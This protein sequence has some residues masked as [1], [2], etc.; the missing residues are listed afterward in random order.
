E[1]QAARARCSLH[2]DSPSS[3][4]VGHWDRMRLE[5]V[6]SNLLSNALKFGAGHPVEVHLSGV[7]SVARIEV[8]DHGIGIDDSGLE[9][10]FERFE[11]AAPMRHYG[12]F[13][14]GLWIVRKLVDAFGGR[15]VA[16]NAAD[17]GAAFVVDLP[18]DARIALAADTPRPSHS[19]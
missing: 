9:R 13:G 4:V 14:L 6:L 2:I 1:N 16:R 18:V 15:V 8:R 7:D 5:Q 3:P 12:G 17:G 19:L 10:I 11:Q